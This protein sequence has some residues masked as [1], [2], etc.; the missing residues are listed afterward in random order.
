M[1]YRIQQRATMWVETKVEADT[2]EEAL[3]K[4]EEKMADGD[5]R[6]L[7]DTFDLAGEWWAEDENRI[8]Q[9]LPKEYK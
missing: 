4:A 7:D 5:Y 9:E 8:Q 2:L 6:E 3:E 1:E